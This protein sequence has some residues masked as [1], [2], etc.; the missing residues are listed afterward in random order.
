[1]VVC[2]SVED[3]TAEVEA[4]SITALA[5]PAAVVDVRTED[6]T[7]V[8]NSNME[9]TMHT[10]QSLLRAGFPRLLVLSALALE[11]RRRRLLLTTVGITHTVALKVVIT[12]DSRIT[13]SLLRLTAVAT[14]GMAAITTTRAHMVVIDVHMTTVETTVV[15][16]TIGRPLRR[17]TNVCVEA[18]DQHSTPLPT[19]CL[20]KDE[21]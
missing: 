8:I 7:V 19:S 21:I 18:A 20:W 4:E 3:T 1:M 5:C 12:V 11:R 16:E 17:Q 6:H 15:A 14:V 2:H 10:R 9:D 13:T